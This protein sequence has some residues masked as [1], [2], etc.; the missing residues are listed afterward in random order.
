[1]WVNYKKKYEEKIF[2]LYPPKITE[3]RSRIRIHQPEI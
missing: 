1:M 2:F 3:E